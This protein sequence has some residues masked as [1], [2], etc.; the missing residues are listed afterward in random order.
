M[1]SVGRVLTVE[2]DMLNQIKQI[3][4]DGFHSKYKNEFELYICSFELVDSN[5]ESVQLFVFPVMPNSIGIADHS[6]VSVTKTGSGMVNLINT[7]SNPKHID[8]SGDFGRHLKI[9]VNNKT[10]DASSVN[11]DS[12]SRAA[13]ENQNEFDPIIKTGYG[14]I[15]IMEKMIDKSFTLDKYGNPY[16]L[17]FFNYSFNSHFMVEVMSKRFEQNIQKNMIW[18]YSI[19]LLATAP[20]S[21]VRA[22]YNDTL[23]KIIKYMSINRQSDFQRMNR[24]AVELSTPRSKRKDLKRRRNE[25]RRNEEKCF[26]NTTNKTFD[27]DLYLIESDDNPPL[28]APRIVT[29]KNQNFA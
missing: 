28:Y 18:S 11:I 27:N 10:K 15:K 13:T 1:A 14:A 20:A 22:N 24:E 16:R 23:G 25:E 3:G 9:V 7:S 4:K 8:L 21:L 19:E 29:N 17:F 6:P 5:D 2:T 12:S 26:R